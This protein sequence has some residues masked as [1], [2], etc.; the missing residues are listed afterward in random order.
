MCEHRMRLVTDSHPDDPVLDL[1]ISHALLHEVAAGTAGATARVFRPGPTLAFGRVDALAPGLPAAAAAAR[2]HGFVGLVRLGGGRAAAYDGGSVLFELVV[3]TATVVGGIEARFT[4]AAAV[5][6]DALT[7]LGLEPEVGEL[8]G[9][10]CPGRFSLHAGGVKLAGLAQRS[11]RGAALVSGVVV[12][13]HGPLIRAVLIDVYRAL[14]FAWDAHTAG[15]AD[16]VQPAVDAARA[17]QA[18]VGALAL[19]HALE[20]AALSPATVADARRRAVAHA[21]ALP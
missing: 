8:P 14:D 4:A 12:A 10:Y 2:D 3:P 19:R 16:E 21:I 5:L 1:A 7:A 13:E 6:V 17:A 15:A 20:P 11:I 9:E 18:V